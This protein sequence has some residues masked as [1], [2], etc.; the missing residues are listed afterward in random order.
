[1]SGKDRFPKTPAPDRLTREDKIKL[2]G[3]IRSRAKPVQ[4]EPDPFFLN[5]AKSKKLI[6]Y[7]V[8]ECLDWHRAKEVE[9]SSWYQAVQTW[10]SKSAREEEEKRLTDRPQMQAPRGKVGSVL[11]DVLKELETK[12]MFEGE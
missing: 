1:M 7:H 8:E 12:E 11:S 6:R 3:W 10:I 5:L 9:R 2:I 4:R